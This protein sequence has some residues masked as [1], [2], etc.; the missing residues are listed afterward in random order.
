MIEIKIFS[1]NPFQV[2]TYLLYDQTGESVIV[3]AA[4]MEDD[5]KEELE[6]YIRQHGLKPVRL[7]YTHCHVDHTVGN[8]F[9]TE[10]FGLQAEV[11]PK[12]KLFWETAREF[13]SVFNVPFD[14][15]MN[16]VRFLEDGDEVRFGESALR[17]LYTPGH[18]DGSICLWSE[19]QHFVISGDVL[20]CGS[21]G[22]TDLPT[23]NFRLLEESIKEKL[24][25]L[26]DKTVVYPGHGPSTTI[27]FEKA[28]NPFIRF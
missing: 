23:G 5:E 10:T 4:C 11:H 7:I 14:K 24:Y 2:N 26:D 18:A 9:V 25:T 3:D 13:S 21:I 1:F 28:S 22:R 6:Q 12:G 16:P 19:A 17:V 20:F 8:T 27:G 15:P